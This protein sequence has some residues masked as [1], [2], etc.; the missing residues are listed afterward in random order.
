MG[1]FLPSH[2]DQGFI[3]GL[4]GLWHMYNN[5]NNYVKSPSEFRSSTWFPALGRAKPVKPLELWILLT[6]VVIFIFKQLSHAT[7]DF[8]AGSIKME[9]LGRFQ[10]VIFALFFLVYAIVGLVDEY[11]T[12]LR[13]PVGALH[14]TFATGFL[15][16]L[17]VFHFGHH[18]GDDVKSFVHMLMQII[19][20]FLVL[21]M[22]LEVLY[23]HSILVSVG[24]CIML[25]L[26]GTWFAQIGFLIHYPSFVPLGCHTTEEMEY[27]IC[28]TH[29]VLMRAKSLQVLIFN[30][31]LLWI[32][33]CTFIG[34]AILVSGTKK[35][36][37]FTPRLKPIL[38]SILT[39]GHRRALT[40]GSKQKEESV[41]FQVP[42]VVDGSDSGESDG[43][44]SATA[45]AVKSLSRRASRRNAIVQPRVVESSSHTPQEQL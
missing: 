9:H 7:S 6:I 23:P 32:L 11:T 31:Q 44:E 10:H 5:L 33:V 15:M 13:L 38:P 1:W 17:V 16:E 37:S 39:P 30:W 3:F 4:L 35:R 20:V 18:P 45:S 14:C 43:E 19:L 2:I 21:L 40:P 25:I 41:Y 29:E 12:L 28:P 22:F 24:R 34:Y 8:A 42:D 27:P 26:K 36:G